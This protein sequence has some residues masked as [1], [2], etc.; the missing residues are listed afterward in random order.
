MSPDPEQN[1]RSEAQLTPSQKLDK[2]VASL[3]DRHDFDVMEDRMH[4][5]TVKRSPDASH[6]EP[7]PDS[8]WMLTTTGVDRSGVRVGIFEKYIH[9]DDTEPSRKSLVLAEALAYS[10][11]HARLKTP[12]VELA[13]RAFSVVGPASPGAVEP[14]VDQPSNAMPMNEF[15]RLYSVPAAEQSTPAAPQLIEMPDWSKQGAKSVDSA[16]V[17]EPKPSNIEAEAKDP[18][19]ELTRGLSSSDVTH[20][21]Y[22]AQALDT[23]KYAQKSGDGEGSTR[24]G[25]IAG[26]H[27]RELSADAK[28]VAS[29]YAQVYARLNR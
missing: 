10:A 3:E 28:A 16:V 6:K 21:E 17:Q 23:K 29:R 4:I 8:G 1:S 14:F 9:P 19:G 12:Q 26:Q 24:W 2:Y 7:W 15:R 18:L 11:E 20:L 13:D 5:L 25:Q 22:Y 27:M